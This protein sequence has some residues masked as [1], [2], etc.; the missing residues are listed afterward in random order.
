MKNTSQTRAG[1]VTKRVSRSLV[2]GAVLSATIVLGYGASAE[3]G[4]V[5]QVSGVGTLASDSN[6]TDP[7]IDPIAPCDGPQAATADYGLVLTGD[8]EGCVYG[9]IET[10]SYNERNGIYNEWADETFVNADKTG[11]FMMREHFT[12]RFD[13][14]TGDQIFG[15]CQHPIVGDSGTGVYDGISGRLDFKDDVD[16]GVAD[17]RGHYKL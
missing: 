15:R 5:T 6:G 1:W 12:A 3:A 8:F 13:P 2:A 9:V 17:Y 14:D 11:S 7:G 16:A 4:G 10:A